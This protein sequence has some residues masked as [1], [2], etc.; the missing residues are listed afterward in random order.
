MRC[1]NFQK[2][3]IIFVL[4]LINELFLNS[5]RIHSLIL[6]G[7]VPHSFTFLMFFFKGHKIRLHSLRRPHQAFPLIYIPLNRPLL[8]LLII[9]YRLVIPFRQFP[10]IAQI[11]YLRFSWAMVISD[12]NHFLSFLTSNISL[13]N[14]LFW[15]KQ[16]IYFFS[17]SYLLVFNSAISL[18]LKSSF[19]STFFNCYIYGIALV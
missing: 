11:T 12:S 16:T 4:N 10:L 7:L 3:I 1:L 6:L 13:S 2:T 15:S 18:N 8:I 19:F 5:L 17:N 9:L 14:F